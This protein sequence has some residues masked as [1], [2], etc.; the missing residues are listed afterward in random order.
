EA[1]M[2]EAG[3]RG[4]SA[5]QLAVRITLSQNP[6]QYLL[7]EE[8]Q[9]VDERQVWIS[10]WKRAAPPRN[11]A[12][13][14]SLESKLAWEQDE[15]ILDVAFVGDAMLVLS[16][17]K[18]TLH[19]RGGDQSADLTP[20]RP[21]PR[22]LRGRLRVTAGTF[23]AFLPG[24]SCA[25]STAGALRMECRPSD[26]AWVL[27]SGSRYLL[28]ASFAAG[29]NYFDGRVVTQTGA[30]KTIA[31]FFSAAAV[32][33]PGRTLWVLAMLDGRAQVFD[34]AFNPLGSL[35]PWGSDIA[36]AD[37][38]CGSGTSPV[39]AARAGDGS[40]PDAVQAFTLS[41]GAAVPLTAP[42]TYNGPVTAL[43]PSGASSVVVARDLSTGKYGAYVV[44][45]ACGL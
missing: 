27:E 11:A 20:P 37:A 15:P 28:L 24:M 12:P 26:E 7:V 5:P 23:Q 10:G 21:W 29:R 43:W 22:D 34:A 25:G 17:S 44:S 40:E 2:G 18:V 6:T 35:T 41:G 4:N 45:V 16:P 14:I 19:A 13:G 39:I 3:S 42:V 1:A 8:A 31:P 30:R 38:R 32:E 33:E 36:G 9:S